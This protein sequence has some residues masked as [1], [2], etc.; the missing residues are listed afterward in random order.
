MNR[1]I[2]EYQKSFTIF[3][4]Y[5][6]A[7]NIVKDATIEN[8]NE[9]LQMNLK[10]KKTTKYTNMGCKYILK[11]GPR[12]NNPCGKKESE[13]GY[14]KTHFTTVSRESKK[15]DQESS[16]RTDERNARELR[17]GKANDSSTTDDEHSQ[18]QGSES[19]NKTVIRKNKYN[20]F[21]FGN[22]GLIIRSA[23]EKYIVAK[24]G[25]L[26]EW[27]PLSNRDIED[28]KRFHLRYKIIDFNFKGE[29]INEDYIKNISLG[30]SLKEEEKINNDF[31]SQINGRLTGK[32][33]KELEWLDNETDKEISENENEFL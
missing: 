33:I 4:K 22:T 8:L 24:E 5:L 11:L 32:R 23:K 27:L 7:D 6:I 30:I 19:E 10:N 9:L 15:N 12:K 13:N 14:C 21:V 31:S 3:F 20:N 26:G 29:K 17:V 16:L 1:F 2:K 28:C 18:S 25:E